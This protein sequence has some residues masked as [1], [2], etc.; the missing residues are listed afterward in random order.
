MRLRFDATE[1]KNTR[2]DIDREDVVVRGVAEYAESIATTEKGVPVVVVNDDITR[3]APND[4]ALVNIIDFARGEVLVDILGKKYKADVV[5]GF[6]SQGE[7]EL[8]D[9][10]NLVPTTF[11]YKKRD[12]VSTISHSGEHSQK[13]SSLDIS[14]SQFAKKV[15]SFKRKIGR[16]FVL[17]IFLLIDYLTINFSIFE[18]RSSA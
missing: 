1:R 9:V 18:I 2:P 6:A 3:Y 10:E 8:H 12:A 16:I 11:A 17:P 7:C 14:I 4:K 15:N 13:R 5:I